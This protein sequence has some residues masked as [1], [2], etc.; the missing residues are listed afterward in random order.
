MTDPPFYLLS[1]V[2]HHAVENFEV[3]I[4]KSAY[5]NATNFLV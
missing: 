2:L 1:V 4:Q 5:F 3:Q